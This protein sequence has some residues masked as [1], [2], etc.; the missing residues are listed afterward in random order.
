MHRITHTLFSNMANT[1]INKPE[2]LCPYPSTSPLS[3]E[4]PTLH[5][6]VD[7]TL[8]RIT[9]ASNASTLACASYP[10]CYDTTWRHESDQSRSSPAYQTPLSLHSQTL[11]TYLHIAPYGR[12]LG[13]STLEGPARD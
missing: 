8:L 4:A 1:Q 5:L 9:S 3:C 10:P 11:H 2:C 6:S 13:T 7:H 12:A